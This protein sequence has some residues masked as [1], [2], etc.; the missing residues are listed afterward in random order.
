MPMFKKSLVIL[1]VLAVAALGGTMY[2]YSTQDEALK[3][4]AASTEPADRG[5]PQ[6]TVTVYVTG[7]NKPGVVTLAEG[8]RIS[9]AV[10]A[11]GGVL[12]TADANRVNMAQVLK[13]GQKITI[14]E[15]PQSSV[16]NKGNDGSKAGKNVNSSGDGNLVNINTA[17]AQALDSLPGVGPS[18]AQKIIDYRESEGGFQSIDDLKKI[19]GIGEAKF[20]KLKDRVCI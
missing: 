16:G 1:L 17:D 15:K 3:L 7:V 9:D 18:T 4:D 12:P 19:K 20:A 8:S 6:S 13:D 5:T 2:G 14:P 10:N 11:C